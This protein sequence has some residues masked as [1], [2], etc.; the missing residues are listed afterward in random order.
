MG[1]QSSVVEATAAD[2]TQAGVR[3]RFDTALERA[4]M[5]VTALAAR[6]GVSAF[7]VQKVRARGSVPR[8]P[9]VRRAIARVLGADGMW[10][11]HGH[12]ADRDEA[13]GRAAALAPALAGSGAWWTV[14]DDSSAPIAHAG[15]M[16]YVSASMAPEPGDRVCVRRRGIGRYEFG[17]ALG[18]SAEGGHRIRFAAGPEE[19]AAVDLAFV[20]VV[21][22]IA[23]LRRAD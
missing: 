18:A 1:G 4:G 20:R 15:E 5:G 10:L 12:V 17:I 19:L 7:V 11:W 2:G 21:P 13:A 14:E 23:R 3:A 8:D 6:A 16:A 9:A 22:M